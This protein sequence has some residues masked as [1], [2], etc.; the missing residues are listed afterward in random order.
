[1]SATKKESNFILWKVLK[2]LETFFCIVPIA[3]M[4]TVI[5]T[6]VIFRYVLLNPI[7]WAEEFTKVCLVWAVM[8]GSSYAFYNKLN[9]GVTFVIDNFHGNVRHVIE[10]ILLVGT[11]IFMGTI[12]ILGWSA[13]LNVVGKYTNAAHIPMWI[14]YLAIPVGGAMSILRLIQLVL[15]EINAMKAPAEPVAEVKEA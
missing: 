12:M 3:V 1:M 14:P 10:I 2:V 9:V 15:D 5:F 8:G 7:G 4:T 6:S 11:I 13:M